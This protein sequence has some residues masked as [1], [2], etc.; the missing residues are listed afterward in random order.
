MYC[1]KL[2]WKNSLCSLRYLR[3]HWENITN[4]DFKDIGDIIRKKI[5]FDVCDHK[6]PMYPIYYTLGI[7]SF[8]WTCLRCR[9]QTSSS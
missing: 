4:T 6:G 5:E 9:D 3:T 2:F 1:Q 7:P 8:I